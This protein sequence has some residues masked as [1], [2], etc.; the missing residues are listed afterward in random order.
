MEMESPQGRRC[1]KGSGLGESQDL[2]LLFGADQEPPCK[3][4][5]QSGLWS[6]WTMMKISGSGGLILWLGTSRSLRRVGS[7]I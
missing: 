2:L 3:G 6:V 5:G 4:K 7:G 1:F